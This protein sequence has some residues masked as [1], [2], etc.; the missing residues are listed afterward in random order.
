MTLHN[1]VVG[2]PVL[3]AE[4]RISNG[5]V[6]IV[7]RKGPLRTLHADIYSVT[8]GQRGANGV[9]GIPRVGGENHFLVA[10][11][12]GCAIRTL[13][14]C[15]R[16]AQLNG[17]EDEGKKSHPV[18]SIVH[19]VKAADGSSSTDAIARPTQVNWRNIAVTLIDGSMERYR[20]LPTLGL[21]LEPSGLRLR[22]VLYDPGM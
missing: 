9:N 21:M 13:A 7:T 17:N 10:L 5:N 22:I 4:L 8:I 20:L 14:C 3:R 2:I 16:S 6:F 18:K 15:Q 11:A 19:K 12:N 1:Q